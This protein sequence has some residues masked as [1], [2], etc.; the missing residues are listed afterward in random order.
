MV[1]MASQALILCSFFFSLQTLHTNLPKWPR[2]QPLQRDRFLGAPG[3]GIPFD[4]GEQFG[5][6]RL[7]STVVLLF[8][9]PKDFRF[10]LERGQQIQMGCAL[11]KLAK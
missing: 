9:A 3:K 8:E 4:K 11:S 2:G 10:D 6:F 7:G 1:Y 5:E